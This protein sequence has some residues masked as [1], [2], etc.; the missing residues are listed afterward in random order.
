MKPDD[1]KQLKRGD[2]LTVR[3]EVRKVSKDGEWIEVQFSSPYSIDI[4]VRDIEALAP[5]V[6]RE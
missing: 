1:A 2:K 3:G 6:G 5:S 4:L